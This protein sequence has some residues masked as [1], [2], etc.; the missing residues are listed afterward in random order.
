MIPDLGGIIEYPGL[1]SVPDNFF[2]YGLGVFFF[3]IGPCNELIPII[4]IGLVVLVVVE[5]QGSCA[6]I[7]LERVFRKRQVGQCERHKFSSFK[8]ALVDDYSRWVMWIAKLN[9]L[10]IKHAFNN[11]QVWRQYRIS[12]RLAKRGDRLRIGM[13]GLPA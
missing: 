12:Q 1:G 4:D 8:V 10:Q 5:L 9:R 3:Q 11:A 2:D 6:E 13:S 7:G